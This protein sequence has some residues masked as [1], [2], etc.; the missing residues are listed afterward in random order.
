MFKF[1]IGSF[2]PKFV[3]FI[4][5]DFTIFVNIPPS[6]ENF[7]DLVKYDVTS[8]FS[9]IVVGMLVPHPER[10]ENRHLLFP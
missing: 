10:L 1:K 4:L 2:K 3:V 9:G 6:L 8:L 5:D 7:V